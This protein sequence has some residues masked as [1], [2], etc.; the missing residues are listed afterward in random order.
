MTK[1]NC[2]KCGIKF[3]VSDSMHET[4]QRTHAIFYC[5]N[6][7]AQSFPDENDERKN[8]GDSSSKLFGYIILLVTLSATAGLISFN[9]GKSIGY[10][11]GYN[12]ARS[13]YRRSPIYLQPQKLP[14]PQTNFNDVFDYSKSK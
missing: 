12:R 9:V 6:G 13:I 3:S 7:H 1:I 11:Q 8:N 5:P 14:Y 2:C 10:D 4:L